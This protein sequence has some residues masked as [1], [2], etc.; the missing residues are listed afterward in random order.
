[1][2]T[3][4]RAAPGPARPPG[5]SLA[6]AVELLTL[7]LGVAVA[8]GCAHRA[9]SAATA[10]TSLPSPDLRGRAFHSVL[11]VAQIPDLG[12]RTAMEDRFAARRPSCIPTGRRV[13]PPEP[14][15]TYRFIPSYTVFFPGRDYSSADVTAIMRQYHMDATLLITV[16]QAGSSS[17]FV[18]P[19]YASQCAGFSFSSGCSQVTTQ[20]ETGRPGPWP[21]QQFSARLFDAADGQGVWIATATAG[22]NFFAQT[23]DLVQSMADK[24]KER[25][26]ADRVVQ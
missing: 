4:E 24:T 13:C 6:A 1:M 5:R 17:T 20:A 2:V 10:M 21:W 26:L 22:G 14:E 9:T 23:I 25:L 15:P 7:G 8:A 12:L 16:G 19:T 11:V 3:Q 18:P